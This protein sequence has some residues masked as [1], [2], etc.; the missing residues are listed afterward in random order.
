MDDKSS[1]KAARS[2]HLNHFFWGG[3]TNYISGKA[4]A[5]VVKF[6]IQVG[7]VKSQ[8]T[9]DKWPLKGTW[10]GSRDPPDISVKA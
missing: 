4:E 3:G 1:L 6:C 2:D 9:D 10:S 8:H 5:V 7:Y